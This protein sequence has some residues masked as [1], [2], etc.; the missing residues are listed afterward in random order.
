MLWI[1]GY[2][3]V[4]ALNGFFL[5]AEFVGAFVTRLFTLIQLL[6]LLWVASDLLTEERMAREVLYAYIMAATVLAFGSMLQLPGFAAGVGSVAGTRAAAF[7]FNPNTLATLMALAAIMLTGLLFGAEP[8][9]HPH[10]SP[11]LPPHPDLPPRRGEGEQIRQGGGDLMPTLV[12]SLRERTGGPSDAGGSVLLAYAKK[13]V[14]GALMLPL[15]AVLVQTG[16]R[17]GVAAFASGFVVYQLPYRHSRPRVTALLIA[18]LGGLTL[19]YMVANS[20]IAASRW[21][22][23]LYEGNVAG[24]D[25]IALAALEL[26][27]ERPLFG[28]QP[29]RF[30]YQL[31]DRVGLFGEMRDAHNLFL[32]LFLEVGVVG[33]L[34]FLIGLGLCGR[35]AWRARWGNLGLLPLALL[36]TTL[37]ANMAN[38]DLVRKHLWIVL[39]LTL[40]AAATAGR[41]RHRGIKTSRPGV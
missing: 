27:Q 38:T 6:V 5:P 34:P 8:R 31:G 33:A 35:A 11:A 32:H 29:I 10:P 4:F 36:V 16:S 23:T 9:V 7:G 18:A 1:L 13:L 30:W 22:Q 24:R 39:A 28:W 15:L 40:A 19:V 12:S 17:T 14:F 3:V 2:V 41:R 21:E 25:K 37:A 20:S 26:M